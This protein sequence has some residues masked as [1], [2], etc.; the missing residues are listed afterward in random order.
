MKDFFNTEAAAKEHRV[1]LDCTVVC[2]CA[3]QDS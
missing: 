1:L 2:G 3:K